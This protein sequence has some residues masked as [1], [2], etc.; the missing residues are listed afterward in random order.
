MDPYFIKLL[1]RAELVLLAGER[2]AT[3]DDGEGDGDG[4]GC[5]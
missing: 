3:G 5:D 4:D 1:W 2:G